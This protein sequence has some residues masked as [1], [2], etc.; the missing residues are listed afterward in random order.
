MTTATLLVSALTGIQLPG[1]LPVPATGASH[2]G[3]LR[4]VCHCPNPVPTNPCLPPCAS[5]LGRPLHDGLTR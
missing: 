3:W 2:I 5:W 1:C 4:A